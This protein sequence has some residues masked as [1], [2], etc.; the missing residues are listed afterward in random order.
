MTY[1]QRSGNKYH[2]KSTEYNGHVYHS[3][4]EAAYAQELDL[5]V[6]AKDIKSW[7]RQV[8]LDLRVNGQK[9]C[10]YYIDFVI[11]HNDDSKEYVECKGVEMEVWKLKWRILEATFDTDFRQHPN[12]Q[13]TVMKQTSWGSPRKR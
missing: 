2:A 6:R 9:I 11:L 12:D 3:K 8:K 10:S 13:L 1:I 4:L 7:D 5:R